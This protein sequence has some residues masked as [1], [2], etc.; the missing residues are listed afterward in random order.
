[1]NSLLTCITQNYTLERQEKQIK[2]L[3]IVLDLNLFINISANKPCFCKISTSC[4]PDPTSRLESDMVT[5]PDDNVSVITLA[6]ITGAVL[7]ICI[8]QS[9]Y[10]TMLSIYMC[11][12]HRNST[13]NLY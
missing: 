7:S 11:I 8:E 9:Q 6:F 4:T 1:M 3:L 5:I 2:V 10:T 12:Y 13:V